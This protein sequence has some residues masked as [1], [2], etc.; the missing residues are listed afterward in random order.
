MSS[1]EAACAHLPMILDDVKRAL[2][3]LAEVLADE[4]DI[5]SLLNHVC[6]QVIRAV[7]GVDHATITMVHE[8]RPETEAFTSEDGIELDAT[9]YATRR[10]PCLEAA[11][12]AQT[13]RGNISEA[14]KH[15]PEFAPASRTAGL[16]GFLTVPLIVN[17]DYS[18]AVN[19]YS[20]QAQ[21]FAELDVHL[22]RLY[23]SAVGAILRTYR[24]YEKASQL[25]EHLAI[26]L[27][28]RAVIDQAKGVLIAVHGFTDKEAF[29]LLVKQSQRENVKLR[30][31]A[32]RF[33]ETVRLQARTG[34]S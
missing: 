18:G 10:G 28:T 33:L 1:D 7:P 19:C 14:S 16:S 9:Q 34:Q 23:T 20:R 25:A 30:D 6:H 26:A 21:G 31:L 5:N 12:S 11:K 13:R 17:G 27:S 8:H 3:G 29:E 15:W 24:H 2:D 22:L 32:Y 4:T